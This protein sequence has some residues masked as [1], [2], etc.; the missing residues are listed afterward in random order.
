MPIF[1]F[2]S[3][4]VS[5]HQYESKMIIKWTSWGWQQSQDRKSIGDLPSLQWIYKGNINRMVIFVPVEPRRQAAYWVLPPF[6]LGAWEHVIPC[7]H[8]LCLQLCF[9]STQNGTGGL[10]VKVSPCQPISEPHWQWSTLSDFLQ[11]TQRSLT[12]SPAQS[13]AEGPL[14]Q[15]GPG[16]GT[17]IL[18]VS[19]FV[20]LGTGGVTSSHPSI[21]LGGF[22]INPIMLF[23]QACLEN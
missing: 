15:R 1:L 23:F 17:S 22:C 3:K 11:T 16:G 6:P 9:P 20:S 5:N 19:F 2:F 4:V 13:L 8:L 10:L 14:W 7:P 21:D 18:G 12:V